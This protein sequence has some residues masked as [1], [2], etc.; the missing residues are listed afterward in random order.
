[1]LT[2]LTHKPLLL[3][4]GLAALASA[5]SAAVTDRLYD[6]TDDY[7]RANGVDPAH[8]A[9]RK[10]APSASAVVDVPNF[11]YQRP[12]R[13]IGTNSAYG[14]NG[15]PAFFAVMA[16][17]GPDMFT[18]DKAGTKARSIAD[19]FAEYIFP[20]LGADPTALGGG[21]QSALHDNNHGYFSNNPLGLWI[22][23]W[24]NY[25]PSAFNTRDGQKALADLAKKNGLALDGTPLIKTV[26]DVENLISKG[27]VTRL[28]R[29]DGLRYA[30]CPEIHDPRNGGI[31]PDAFYNPIKK[32]DGTNLEQWFVDAFN[33]L[34][35]TGDWNS[36][37]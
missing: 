14:A 6:F 35:T 9:G 8:L 1:M 28:T 19:S 24:V 16:G 4:A 33:S 29:N 25:T 36:N 13:V 3:L 30:V 2:V 26:S 34:K 7:Y 23:V 18:A 15:F 37:P 22:H 17:G 21:R 12:V 11:S 32:A 5:A 10:Q 27:F 31:A 20:K